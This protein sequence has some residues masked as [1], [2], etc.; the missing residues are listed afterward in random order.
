MSIYNYWKYFQLNIYNYY[1]LEV[2]R[3]IT[4]K[5]KKINSASPQKSKYFQD[6]QIATV[7]ARFIWQSRFTSIC[8]C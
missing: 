6:F 3:D 4:E 2:L 8:N 1:Y 7:I 5:T